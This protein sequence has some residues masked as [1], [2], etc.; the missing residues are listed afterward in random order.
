MPYDPHVVFNA[1]PLYAGL[2]DAGNALAEGISRYHQNKQQMDATEA[3]AELMAKNHPD[4]V[5]P[6]MLEKF[7]KGGLGQRQALLG[8][9]TAELAN[10]YKQKELQM[11][12][13]HQDT[14]RY[15]IDVKDRR[16]AAQDQHGQDVLNFE[17]D[18]YVNEQ[19]AM[20]N[21][22]TDDKGNSYMYMPGSKQLPQQ[23]NKKEQLLPEPPALDANG[24]PIKNADGT[25]QTAPWETHTG[26]DG[27]P[28]MKTRWN[29]YTGKTE[30]IN[31]REPAANPL[32][33]LLGGAPATPAPPADPLAGGAGGG[34]APAPAPAMPTA[35]MAPAPGAAPQG[36]P[37]T[38]S[39]YTSAAA[40]KADVRAG[41]LPQ[42]QGLQILRS[43][44]GYK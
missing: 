44:F 21:T 33:A 43:Q 13:Q 7:S 35:P 42:A 28:I 17:K 38:A 10:Q 1:S 8:Q 34:T 5:D 3:A 22:F 12:Q 11:Q 37:P 32:S 40:V 9:M 41:K 36:A 24:R 15:A 14:M 20:P 39:P 19:N 2:S 26:A 25:L 29:P 30:M 18:R 6:D 27:K 4:L 23:T 16:E 31:L